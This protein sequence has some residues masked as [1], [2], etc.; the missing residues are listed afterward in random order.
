MSVK[1]GPQATLTGL[2]FHYDSANTLKSWK[3]KPTTNY[4]YTQNP[5]VDTSY[6]SYVATATGTWTAKHPD[7]IRVYNDDGTEITNSPKSETN[8]HVNTSLDLFQERVKLLNKLTGKKIEI[9]KNKTD[10]L[11]TKILI[12]IPI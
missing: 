5:R 7:A 2:I 11:G 9:E 8:C 3:G 10:K 1:V 4:V 12:T 6:S